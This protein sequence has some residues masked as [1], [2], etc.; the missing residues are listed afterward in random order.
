MRDL[1]SLRHFGIV[2][3]T[4]LTVAFATGT[5][6]RSAPTVSETRLEAYQLQGGLL[7]DLC[8]EMSSDHAH[9]VS[10]SLCHLV[11][12][13]D[14]PQTAHVL[15]E[16]ERKLFSSVILPQIQR[17]ALQ[18]RDPATPPRGPPQG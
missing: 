7:S 11:A 3:V 18:L 13:S 17:A 4:L 16:I 12:G 1:A 10:C 15:V 5:A 9:I 14:L 2:F 8:N 6:A